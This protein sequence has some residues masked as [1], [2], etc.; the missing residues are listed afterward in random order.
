MRDAQHAD[1]LA[2]VVGSSAD[3]IISQSLDGLILSWNPAAERLFGYAS[4]DVLRR[5][6]NLLVPDDR[7]HEFE[8]ELDYVRRGEPMPNV[9]TL[10]RH[11][12]GRLIPVALSVAPMIGE[13]G[14]VL[15]AVKVV[16]DLSERARVEA[17]L[18][19]ANQRLRALISAAK[20]LTEATEVGEVWRRTVTLAE[21]ALTADA[22]AAWR[23]DAD[24][25]WFVGQARGVS[26]AFAARTVTSAPDSDRGRTL[27]QKPLYFDD[28]TQSTFGIMQEAYRAEGIRSMAV[29]PLV[30]Q[31]VPRGTLVLY[32]RHPRTLSD[33]ERQTGEA[34][35][36][37]A[38]AALGAVES[39]EAHRAAA[40]RAAFATRQAE[41]LSEATRVLNA[42]LDYKRT[43]TALTSLA[44]PTI[45]DWCTADMLD[46]GGHLRRLSVAHVDPEKVELAHRLHEKYPPDPNVP[47]GLHE[48]VRTGRPAM[49]SRIP[50]ELIERAARD[51]EHRELVK[52]L[53]LTSFMCVP[54]VTRRGVVGAISFVSA[55]SGREYSEE[56]LRFATEVARRASLAIE[57]SLA[58]EEAD[59]ANRL[60]DEFLATLSHEIR[61]P[62][63]AVLG[64]VRMLRS[65]V[66]GPER[67]ATALATVERNAEALH[68][69]IADVLD[70]ERIVAGRLQ[71]QMQ[72]ASVSG[73]VEQ[74]V[75]TIGP[76]AQAKGI[77]ISLRGE[78]DDVVLADVDRL[79]QI[80]WN[81]LQNAVK[82]TPEGGRVDVECRRDGN[83]VVLTVADTG[84][85]ISSDFLPH[86]FERFRQAPGARAG[87]GLGLGLAIASQL[88][89]LHGGRIAAAS[90]GLGEG[91]TFTVTLPLSDRTAG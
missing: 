25:R 28:V 7:R 42:S 66:I 52:A 49:L 17:E 62:L 19:A 27:L 74:A 6:V 50:P 84:A 55:E 44:V 63:N 13:D 57:N 45:A 20:V 4:K 86:V 77:A 51:A 48:V 26:E 56:D 91:A 58:Y 37:L 47:G 5:S 78:A 90:P 32:Y 64:Y 88:V 80:V 82:F 59:K 61:T 35:A 36:S 12:D 38:S 18:R 70:V 67:Q 43:L 3:A 34:L 89:E 33:Q 46:E 10:R 21:E 30:L 31:G 22:Y 83:T 53:A 11:Q 60:K 75:A 72:Q 68:R 81:L 2:A 29:F 87:G 65:G 41:F 8:S 40:D 14:R 54:L 76:A 24:G 71:L 9:E 73:V 85:G 23:V 39:Y 69:M 16:R 1:H 15:G 79:H